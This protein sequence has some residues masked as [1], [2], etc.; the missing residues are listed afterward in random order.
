MPGYYY[1]TPLG[2]DLGGLARSMVGGDARQGQAGVMQSRQALIDQQAMNE[3]AERE[4]LHKRGELVRAQITQ[5]EQ[6]TQGRSDLA[7]IFQLLPQ[8]PL[9]ATQPPPSAMPMPPAPEPVAADYSMGAPGLA[10]AV[11]GYV[12]SVPIAPRTR[13][14][15]MAD[16]YGQSVLAGPAHMTALPKAMLGFGGAMDASAPEGTPAPYGPGRL[17]SLSVGA[18][19]PYNQTPLGFNAQETRKAG[20]AAARDRT[21]RRGQDVHAGTQVQIE[22]DIK[23]PGRMERKEMTA[24]GKAGKDAK[25]KKLTDTQ[26]ARLAKDIEQEVRVQGV[27]ITPQQSAQIVGTVRQRVAAGEPLIEVKADVLSSL[28]EETPGE[29]TWYG[30]KGK[31]T[32]TLKMPGQAASA[33]AAAAPAAPAAPKVDES[34]LRAKA[35]AAIK[36]GKNA[37][38]V[39]KRFKELTG[40]DL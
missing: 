37:S 2:H 31:P 30:G 29:K 25:P 22:R 24:A 15:L 39:A 4:L 16:A 17:T 6:Q 20:E 14:Q 9:A 18:G 34:G 36:S 19:E 32:R 27:K 11:G 8:A 12:P 28:V 3:V 21:Q 38:A 1:A 5:E 33:P 40:K 35:Q 23:E 7:G 26:E 13:A 10:N